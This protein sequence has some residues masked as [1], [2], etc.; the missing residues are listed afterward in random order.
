M[1]KYQIA[2]TTE[3]IIL[4]IV[5]YTFACVIVTLGAIGYFRFFNDG[6][7][8]FSMAVIIFL[9]IMVE[10]AIMTITTV[11]FSS[12]IKQH[13]S[14]NAF[15]YLSIF[16][17]WI[18]AGVGIDSTIW[19]LV[20]DKYKV[21][22]QD[23]VALQ[24]NTIR[25]SNL[26]QQLSGF[27]K[28][29]DLLTTRQTKLENQKSAMLKDIK[30]YDRNIRGIIFSVADCSASQDC[31]DR[32]KS[33]LQNKDIALNTLTEYNANLNSLQSDLKENKISS[34][35]I[36]L[37]ID[38][39]KNKEAN[40]KK[41]HGVTVD[42]QKAESVTQ[43]WLM[44]L[45]NKLFQTDLTNP[46]RAFVMILS[47]VVYPIYILFVAFASSNS[48]EMRQL[49]AI[50]QEKKRKSTPKRSDNIINFLKKVIIYLIKTRH[51]K[52]KTVEVEV[53]KEVKVEIEKLIYK[54]GK[55]IVKVEVEKP[56]IIEQEK[57]VEK[58]VQV[59][60]VEKEY[61]IVPAGTDLNRLNKLSS[62]GIVPKELSKMLK[63]EEAKNKNYTMKGLR[64]DQ[65]KTA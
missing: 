1:E 49:R 40:F 21:V 18:I 36:Q 9:F 13:K 3:E 28:Q 53:E 11:K 33:A 65:Y 44:H 22:K 50:E 24:A 25:L 63:E 60:V 59:P 48:Q 47:F 2:R 46:K 17:M 10:V 4:G 38:D 14:I 54:D 51:R 26:Q 8:S 19:H 23:K 45:L 64:H 27:K 52:V 34:K 55:E 57:I 42:N 39:I 61:I 31:Q 62:S 20:E 41:Q 12:H 43:L 30:K 35:K 29:R 56:V 5:K 16:V 32:K 58:I 15:L 37:K 7:W 6:G